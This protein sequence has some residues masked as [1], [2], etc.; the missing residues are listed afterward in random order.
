[1]VWAGLYPKAWAE[2]GCSPPWAAVYPDAQSGW[3]MPELDRV[4]SSRQLPAG[5]MRWE[6]ENEPPSKTMS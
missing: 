6:D 2:H 5:T 3:T 1:M 4:L